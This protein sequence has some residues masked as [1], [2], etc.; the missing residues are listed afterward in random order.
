MISTHYSL[1]E[2]NVAL[3]RM[4]NYEEIKPMIQP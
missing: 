2:V 1:D 3:Q 4:K